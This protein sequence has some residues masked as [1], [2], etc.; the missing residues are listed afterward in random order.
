MAKT[1]QTIFSIQDHW[2]KKKRS[3][4]FDLRILEPKRS[5]LISWAF[6]KS[7]FPLGS[8]KILAIR[9]QDHLIS[10]MHFEGTLDNGDIVKL[11]DR[12][13]CKIIISE[14]NYF[15]IYFNGKKIKGNYNFIRN[16]AS[17][18]AWYVTKS[19]KF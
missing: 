17:K 7:K 19:K 3:G 11:Y 18:D 9:T 10:Y 2:Q 12:G 5:V 6:P 13:S 15:L 1:L 16:V 4:H 14:A 8:E